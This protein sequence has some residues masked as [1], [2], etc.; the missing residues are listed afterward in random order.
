MIFWQLLE[1]P[2]L[3]KSKLGFE[4]YSPHQCIIAISSHLSRYCSHTKIFPHQTYPTPFH[5]SSFLISNQANQRQQFLLHADYLTKSNKFPMHF[6]LVSSIWRYISCLSSQ[7][8][9]L[10]K[11][12]FSTVTKVRCFLVFLVSPRL[13]FSLY[14]SFYLLNVAVRCGQSLPSARHFL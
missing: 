10:T 12:T 11:V 13:N 9:F 7:S 2:Y 6:R 3:Q 5:K 14:N 4:T 1:Y 8:I